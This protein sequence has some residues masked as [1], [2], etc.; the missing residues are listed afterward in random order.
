M[1]YAHGDIGL[2][3][4]TDT[5]IST[6]KIKNDAV[7]RDN[8]KRLKNILSPNG[9][10]LL[11]SCNTAQDIDFIKELSLLT[12][13]Y[14]HANSNLTGGPENEAP[15]FSCASNSKCDDWQLDLVCSPDGNCWYE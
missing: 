12:G 9:H 6:F 15:W 7:I 14:V 2:L 3:C 10:I 13:A 4:I 11:F 1:V 5:C 8:L